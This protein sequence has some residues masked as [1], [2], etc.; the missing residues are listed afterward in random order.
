M[1]IR[2]DG[3]P[4]AISHNRLREARQ[5]ARQLATGRKV[6]RGADGPAALIASVRVRSSLAKHDATLQNIQQA[7]AFTRTADAPLAEVS[8]NLIE[9]KSLLIQAADSTRAADRGLMQERVNQILDGIDRSTNRARFKDRYLFRPPAPPVD[10]PEPVGGLFGE[11][12]KLT[13]GATGPNDWR[14]VSFT[15]ELEDPVVVAGPVTS[16]AG[17]PAMVRIRNVSNTG[18]EFI[19][20]EFEYQDGVH[21]DETLSFLAM[22]RGRFNLP[23]GLTVESGTVTNTISGRRTA[24][25]SQPFDSP[26]LVLTETTSNNNPDAWAERINTVTPAGF[27]HSGRP[28]ESNNSVAHG[29]EH[30][31]YIAIGNAGGISAVGGIDARAGVTPDAVQHPAYTIATNVGATDP[32]VLANMQSNDGG[33]TAWTRLL[34]VSA[35]NITVNIQEEQSANAE[36]NH[37]TETVGWLVLDRPGVLTLVDPITPKVEPRD[38]PDLHRFSIGS[39]AAGEAVLQLGRADTLALG[40]DVTTNG[41]ADLRAGGT[42]NL[43][44]GDLELAAAAV[45]AAIDEVA[46]LRGRI[47]AFERHV[48]D[49]TENQIGIATENLSAAESAIADTDYAEATAAWTRSRILDN[50]ADFVQRIRNDENRRVLA[51]LGA[52]A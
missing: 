49:A 29:A 1:R 8:D 12:I 24:S 4:P 14:A 11:A 17:E 42:L 22:P 7:R 47:G 5:A 16:N 3:P 41:L 36:V 31:S 32:V 27:Q 39:G 25:F 37:T 43:T 19:V 15:R 52:V 18:F 23:G 50:V 33:D 51:L 2:R 28:Q 6:E 9:L 38:S 30:T 48:L 21:A 20:E 40:S 10:A 46:T 34:G 35:D 45:D 44:D 13:A 26:P